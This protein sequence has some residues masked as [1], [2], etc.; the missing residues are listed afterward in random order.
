MR[1]QRQAA[2]EGDSTQYPLFPGIR[3]AQTSSGVGFDDLTGRDF[4]R[5]A[6]EPNTVI[7]TVYADDPIVNSTTYV[8]EYIP[9]PAYNVQNY[10]NAFSLR[11]NNFFNGN[12]YFYSGL[13]PT[14]A[15]TNATYPAAFQPMP[16][17][18]YQSGNWVDKTTPSNENMLI[19]VYEIPND[20]TK[21][22][23]LFT[24]VAYAAD[25]LPLNLEGNAIY[26]IGDTTVSSPVVVVTT[27]GGQSLWG[28][29]TF[30][31]SDCNTSQFTYTNNSGQPGPTG[32]GS[33]TWSRLLN[34]NINGIVC[35]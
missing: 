29:V 27:N 19:Q 26:N 32:S 3:M 33:R 7:S 8:L 17:S 22:A 12:N 5:N 25:G 9:D 2:Y 35:Q 4:I 23:L 31:F 1:I 15:P 14:Y 20:T 16:I 11:F 28:N 24:W 10:N 13:M 30:T 34:L 18:G 21:R 6:V